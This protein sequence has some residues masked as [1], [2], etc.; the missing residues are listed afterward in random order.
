MDL[1]RILVSS[2]RQDGRLLAKISGYMDF[3]EQQLDAKSDF[4]NSVGHN[5]LRV[6]LSGVIDA[7]RYSVARGASNLPTR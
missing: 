4:Y 3:V 7:P 1:G 5:A 6:N 2:W